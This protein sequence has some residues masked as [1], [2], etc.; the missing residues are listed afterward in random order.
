L[1]Y[2]QVI[3]SVVLL[4]PYIPTT[5]KSKYV[6]VTRREWLRHG[7]MILPSW[8]AAVLRPYVDNAGGEASIGFDCSWL[9]C[10]WRAGR[11]LAL[12]L[13][14]ALPSLG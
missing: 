5:A 4:G 12:G 11:G 10:Y 8:G 9:L 14:Q 13:R 7:V 2:P 3:L 1:G 6:L